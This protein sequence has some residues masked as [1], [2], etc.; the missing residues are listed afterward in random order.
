MRWI[1]ASL[2]LVVLHVALAVGAAEASAPGAKRL[3]PAP[4]HAGCAAV[5]REPV[6]PDAGRE[7]LPSFDAGDPLD[8]LSP[9][10][11]IPAAHPDARPWPPLDG[12]PPAIPA[13]IQGR[14]APILGRDHGPPAW[15]ATTVGRLAWL[16]RLLF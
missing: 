2:A 6:A 12:L 5:R 8:G 9:S 13:P 11:L 15:P 4:D 1:Q 3:G 7:S 10:Q 14:P 16:Q